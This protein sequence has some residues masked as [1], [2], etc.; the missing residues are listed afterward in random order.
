MK[1]LEVNNL[2]IVFPASQ[3]EFA[4]VD[5]ISFY[6]D[7]GETVG[8]AGESGSGKTM[9]ALS[10]LKLITPPGKLSSGKIYFEGKNLLSISEKEMRHIRGSE[11]S[12][13]FQ[14]PMAALNPVFTIGK[15]LKETLLA[16]NSCSQNEAYERSVEL[17]NQVGISMPKKRMTSYP[18]ELSGGMR[19]RVMIAMALLC[20]PK[21]L[22]A[23]EPTT[24]LDVTI[25]AQIIEI[26]EKLKNTIN[27]SILL[28]THNLGLIAEM[29]QRVIIM[30]AGQIVEIGDVESLFSKPFHP[31]TIGLLKSVPN[32]LQKSHKLY[33]IPGDVPEIWAMPR[34]CRFS[35][36]CEWVK[37]ICRD[38]HPPLEPAGPGRMLRCWVAAAEAATVRNG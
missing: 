18:H 21:L 30:Y 1:L 4:A 20:N 26:L 28:I 8:L 32:V 35:S 5:D 25:Q 7:Y 2:R 31:Y 10:I 22:L 17:L 24:A 3:G 36:R 15:Q 33:S 29:T 6:I 11:I 13:I 9:T 34:G 38:E 19:Q 37:D 23:D 27:I 16:H 12:M 14:E